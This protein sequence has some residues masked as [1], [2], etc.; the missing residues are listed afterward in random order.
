M[1]D[2]LYRT[3]NNRRKPKMKTKKVDRSRQKERKHKPTKANVDISDF[4]D[5][6]LQ[7]QGLVKCK[8][9]DSR[10]PQMLDICPVCK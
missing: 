6:M 8:V 1:Y 7:I 3:D 4:E 2:D 9:C 10:F 5:E